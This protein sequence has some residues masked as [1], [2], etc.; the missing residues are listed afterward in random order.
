MLNKLSKKAGAR[1]VIHNPE[2]P[3]LP[4]E[5][6]MDLQPNTA[7]SISVQKTDITRMGTPYKPNCTAFWNETEYKD[8]H[9][10]YSLAVRKKSN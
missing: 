9:L 10:P 5:Y 2:N 6:G 4:D 3:P 8:I 1:I 7:S